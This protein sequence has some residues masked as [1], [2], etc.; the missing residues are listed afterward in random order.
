[1]YTLKIQELKPRGCVYQ[2]L[3]ICIQKK[4]YILS[5]KTSIA[6]KDTQF[7][8]F[9]AFLIKQKFSTDYLWHVITWKLMCRRKKKVSFGKSYAYLLL[10]MF[11]FAVNGMHIEHIKHDIIDCVIKMFVNV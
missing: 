6:G 2:A 4:I 9:K 11:T 5:T 7:K 10:L 3:K 8:D 1:M